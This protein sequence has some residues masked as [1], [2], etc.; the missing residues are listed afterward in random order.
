MH[1]HIVEHSTTAVSHSDAVV[2]LEILGGFHLTVAG[3]E[4]SKDVGRSTKL[5]SVLC[6]LILHR[7]R[8]VSRNELI[9]IFYEDE[10][11]SDPVA[12]LRMQIMRIRQFFKSIPEISA[13]PIVGHRGNY[14]WNPE[15]PCR[16][17]LEDFE[18]L[19]SEAE[20]AAG[21]D[22]K[23]ELYR[24]AMELYS[25]NLSLGKDGLVWGMTLDARYHS[26]F[27]SAAEKYAALLLAQGNYPLT[28]EVCLQA[29]QYAPTDEQLYISLI[30][31]LAQQKRYAEA[32]NCY[33]QI[34]ETLHQML[35]I[36][37]S[38]Q[39]QQLY[40]TISRGKMYHEADLGLVI[41]SFRETNGRKT[42]FFCDLDQFRSIYQ[43][44]AR[45]AP[46]TGTCLQVVLVTVSD[47]ASG[48]TEM[49]HILHVL[50]HSLRNSDVVSRYSS[51]QFIVMLPDANLE[52]SHRVM[53]RVSRAYKKSGRDAS[54]F[55]WQIREM[56]IPG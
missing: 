56:E 4:V 51:N 10:D 18:S 44:E 1:E 25:G 30:Q 35:G 54:V 15:L 26:L 41:T 39:L 50:V 48:D 40:H 32:R 42:A 38:P 16:V 17:D 28:E 36:A 11:Q 20:L 7:N 12:A 23:T 43:L 24:R 29:V 37:P 2:Q 45:R 46:R 55:T 33:E 22:A 6:Y 3:R 52:D 49:S 27:T 53:E 19:C 8:A 14:Q 21:D 34:S 47:A 13:Q 31:S 9:D 5:R